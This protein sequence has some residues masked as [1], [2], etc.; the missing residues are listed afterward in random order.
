M[1]LRKAKEHKKVKKTLRIQEKRKHL[2]QRVIE[3]LITKG[4]EMLIPDHINFPPYNFKI[5][6]EQYFKFHT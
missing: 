4:D 3:D 1:I 6:R 2:E 5:N